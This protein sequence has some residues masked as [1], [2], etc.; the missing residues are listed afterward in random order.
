MSP[1]SWVQ[2]N[3]F[4]FV[5]IHRNDSRSRTLWRDFNIA[6]TVHHQIGGSGFC[7]RRAFFWIGVLSSFRHGT[8]HNMF[9][10]LRERKF[11]EMAARICRKAHD[12]E[13]LISRE[14]S[15]G[16][17]VSELVFGVNLFDLDLG[18]AQ[19]MFEHVP[20]CRRTTLLFVHEVSAI[21]LVFS[22]APAE[23]TWFKHV[24]CF[25][26][27]LFHS[28]YIHF[29]CIPSTHGQEIMLV[30]QYPHFSSTFYTREPNSAFYPTL[31]YHPRI[32]TKIT[33]VS[34]ERTYIPNSVLLPIQVQRMF[35][36]IAFLRSNPANGVTIHIS[37]KRCHRVFK[38]SP[39]FGP[40]V[41]WKA[42]PNIR[43]FWLWIFFNN[44]GASSSFTWV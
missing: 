38:F 5:V 44:V 42:H 9:S 24:F 28:G 13:P 33:L 32:L 36:Q 11:S 34:D 21:Q 8:R 4:S 30:R 7:H 29:K 10:V 35:L 22:V 1:V 37:F 26:Q 39:W 40:F 3:S 16:Q 43:T 14:T 19:R 17:N 25:A 18:F 15:F 23:N 6:L 2:A 41:S 27:W 31:W 12:I 20:P